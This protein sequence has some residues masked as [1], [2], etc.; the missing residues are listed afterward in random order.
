MLPP[1]GLSDHSIITGSAD[2]LKDG[3][4]DR[5]TRCARSWR[6]FNLDAFL[7]NLSQSVLVLSPPSDPDELFTEYHHTLTSLL[8]QHAPVRRRRVPSRRSAPWYDN[9]CRQCKRTTRRHERT[10]HRSSAELSVT[11]RHTWRRQFQRQRLLFPRKAADYWST[12]IHE[13]RHDTRL[14]F[15][16]Q[17]LVAALHAV[18]AT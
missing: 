2:L 3:C 18:P 15:E 14:L 12:T 1:G 11:A 16:D 13:C 6:S 7:H 10:Y 8:D 4:D 17:F 9:E 5:V